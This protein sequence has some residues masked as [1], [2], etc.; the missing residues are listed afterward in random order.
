MGWRMIRRTSGRC[1]AS[2]C[3]R[4]GSDAED[5]R[6]R[7]V[8]AGAPERQGADRPKKHQST[9]VWPCFS[10]KMWTQ[11]KFSPN[12]KVVVWSTLHNFYKGRLMFFSMV[13]AA[14]QGFPPIAT[15][16]LGNTTNSVAIGGTIAPKWLF[17]CNLCVY[18]NTKFVLHYLFFW[19]QQVD[20]NAPIFRIFVA[21]CW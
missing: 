20:A 16:P 5:R 2:G 17:G 19:L 13:W 7:E 18:C 8:W 3:G 15:N 4:V 10:S 9:P 12:T 1:A 11:P 6:G 14:L 21:F